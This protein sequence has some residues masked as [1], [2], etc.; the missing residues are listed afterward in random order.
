M[1]FRRG[2][3][4]EDL[5]VILSGRVEFF[6]EAA[7]G[8]GPAVIE[9]S[10]AGEAFGEIALFSGACGTPGARTKTAVRLCR[11]PAPRRCASWKASPAMA[12]AL[13]QTL[14]RRISRVRD[15]RYGPPRVGPGATGK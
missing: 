8:G 11:S 2:D 13:L 12:A 6:V 7:A 14:A 4:G 9:E 3:A 5:F 1:L 15:E 10:S